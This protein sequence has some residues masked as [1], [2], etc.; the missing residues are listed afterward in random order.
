MAKKLK[1]DQLSRLTE[2]YKR[3]P[4]K[5]RNIRRALE[6]K[7][8]D[9]G[10]WDEPF[11]LAQEFAAFGAGIPEGASY[12]ATE[13]LDATSTKD[14]GAGA[15]E[16]DLP[17][18]GPSQPARGMGQLLGG[19]ATGGA[20]WKA[21]TK[22]LRNPA[23]EAAK[24][25]LTKMGAGA[26][27]VGKGTKVAGVAGAAAPEAIVGSVTTGASEG[28]WEAGL[29]A[30]P[31]WLTLG[32]GSELALR[33]LK[34]MWDRRK[35]G[36]PIPDSEVQ[37]TI[38]EVKK[39][40]QQNVEIDPAK[41][42]RHRLVDSRFGDPE[43]PPQ[44][45]LKR[46]TA[47]DDSWM[48][49]ENEGNLQRQLDDLK[50]QDEGRL[51]PEDV[52][53]E[54]H[55]NGRRIKAEQIALDIRPTTNK[56]V[57]KAE[58]GDVVAL[59]DSD[60]RKDLLSKIHN[61]LN[62]IEKR[63]AGQNTPE[64]K[65]LLNKERASLL[66]TMRKVASF[67]ENYNSD[68][69][70]R[71]MPKKYRD[72]HPNED[73]VQIQGDEMLV[74]FNRLRHAFTEGTKKTMDIDDSMFHSFDD[75]LHYM[76]EER[77]LRDALPIE[78]WQHLAD[79]DGEGK[80]LVK[81]Y[82]EFI[83]K[84]AARRLRDRQSPTT[85][86]VS[87]VG[88]LEKAKDP[89]KDLPVS[90]DPVDDVAGPSS[91][92][93][94]G[95]KGEGT[96]PKKVANKLG[97]FEYDEETLAVGDLL[98]ITNSAGRSQD[99]TVM[100]N[101]PDHWVIQTKSGKQSKRFKKVW[102]PEG[103]VPPMR[104]GSGETPGNKVTAS[105]EQ[106]KSIMEKVLKLG[107]YGD[108]GL[109]ARM[110]PEDLNYESAKAIEDELDDRLYLYRTREAD[111]FIDIQ[112]KIEN[113][114]FAQGYRSDRPPDIE[115]QSAVENMSFEELA[116]SGGIKFWRSPT[117]SF[118]LAKN[119]LV[120]GY[121]IDYA[122][123]ENEAMQAMQE[124]LLGK[125]AQ[126]RKLVGLPEKMTVREIVSTKAARAMNRTSEYDANKQK[127]FKI[128]R[129]VDTE[130]DPNAKMP[131]DWDE[132][133]VQAYN[134]YREITN[135][136]ADHLGLAQGKRV[137]DYIHRVF[138]GKAGGLIA[139]DMSQKTSLLSK[140]QADQ[141]T[142]MGKVFSSLGQD[143]NDALFKALNGSEEVFKARGYRGL[144]ERTGSMDYTY[145]LDH[146]TMQMI[147]GSTQRV[148][149][150]KVAKRAH[151]VIVN[152]PAT[153]IHNR[154]NSLP[155]EVAATARHITGRSTDAREKLA[156]WFA[157]SQLFNRG[158]DRIVET[159][160]LA[161]RKGVMGQARA[162]TGI[163]EHEYPEARE[164]AINWLD[165]LE[166]QTRQ[167]DIKTGELTKNRTK[168]PEA[169]Y[170][171][172]MALKINDMRDALADPNLSG[173]ASNAIYRTL[174][175]AKLGINGAHGLMNLTQTL[176]N[177]WPMLDKGY[178]AKGIRDY[179]F[180]K[181]SSINGR[182]AT[183]LLT[184]SGVK[185]DITSTEEFMGVL[186]SASKVLADKAMV[187]SKSSEE[188]NRGVALLAKYRHLTDQGLS[189]GSAMDQALKFVEQTQ[190][191]FN[192]IG[193]PPILRGPMARLLFMFQSYTMHQTD[194][195]QAIMRDAW[196]S[197]KQA[198]KDTDSFVEALKG[199][200]VE[201][202]AKHLTAYIALMGAGAALFPKTNIAE[203]NLPPAVSAVSAMTGGVGR[204]GAVGSPL[205]AFL[206]PT[207][208]TA[209]H[210][211][212]AS[213]DYLSFMTN[214]IG[215]GELSASDN[216]DRANNAMVKFGKS[217]TPTLIR[218][219]LE[220]GTD[221][222]LLEALSLKKYE[223]GSRRRGGALRLPPLNL[224]DL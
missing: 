151:D 212:N 104:G 210:L 52:I 221:I 183:E 185:R 103:M 83:K 15:T 125:Y 180:Q 141:I 111:E 160:G 208:D 134:L 101:N 174:I 105:Y 36:E 159:I 201:K 122:L 187:F 37:D 14:V 92:M 97:L 77:W 110:L 124:R 39:A 78:D 60:P 25:A 12:G 85:E 81:S 64:G 13:L 65:E 150:H 178:T 49:L 205:Q 19:M 90:T 23:E 215:L 63:L 109:S 112:D 145:D 192:R 148:F 133:M 138:V 84:E 117:S 58:T 193:T 162:K 24:S 67:S 195:T 55:D 123:S 222:E 189:H 68:Y 173:P 27:A 127:L 121:F 157:D 7:G 224:N 16:W 198:Y 142:E 169:Y 166:R 188:F 75:F 144:L 168:D 197:G 89:T 28:S 34:N 6:S 10:D 135:E 191:S 143:P 152:L 161:P 140:E 220:D 139:R 87:S 199:D 45:Q 66:S 132:N 167:V 206:G 158:V 43:P 147:F 137:K 128:A 73:A 131:D 29:A 53:A 8:F 59:D 204:Y 176:V 32:V 57:Y 62:T 3:N 175:L 20:L 213:I 200:D 79:F 2:L 116:E 80:D 170:R 47:R 184:E 33:K 130:Y 91:S 42:T 194:F 164:A 207:A 44:L 50:A 48:S 22:F 99:V 69:F 74:D 38:E 153:N 35:A 93:W 108:E 9:L 120:K 95:W 40:Q 98:R 72:L 154:E 129:A 51:S 181:N 61:E 31:Q 165:A 216:L 1:E 172:K 46:E 11:Q 155:K 113:G 118:G 119:K 136:V 71:G 107:R 171:A 30:L 106:R 203:R 88:P 76:Q 26:G 214:L 177:T 115:I 146:L 86:T 179:L 182:T 82:D 190:F 102:T 96:Y 70:H 218:K 209:T 219:A 223:P 211:A 186:P 5:G 21:G 149:T 163:G 94:Q 114:V 18:L 100:Q 56:T 202:L 196:A 217:L 126:V 41:D 156:H 4:A 54:L 17:I